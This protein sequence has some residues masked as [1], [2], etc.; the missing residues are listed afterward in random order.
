MTN[1]EEVIANLAIQTTSMLNSVGHLKSK[2]EKAHNTQVEALAE[3]LTSAEELI[4]SPKEYLL[5]GS[6]KLWVDPKGIHVVNPEGKES[7]VK[8]SK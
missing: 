3:H 7:L 2:I 8:F 5:L 6:Y 1:L 4:S